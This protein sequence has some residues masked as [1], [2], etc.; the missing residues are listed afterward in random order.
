M[1]TEV[2]AETLEEK[3]VKQGGSSIQSE[4]AKATKSPAERVFSKLQDLENITKTIRSEISSLSNEELQKFRVLRE[5]KKKPGKE[6]LTDRQKRLIKIVKNSDEE[7]N[8]VLLTNALGLLV[9]KKP[10]T[11]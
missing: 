6:D 4:S 8:K 7:F 11:D 3:S 1:S 10:Q 5:E 9:M 2:E